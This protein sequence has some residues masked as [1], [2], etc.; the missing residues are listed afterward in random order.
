MSTPDRIERDITA[1]FGETAAPRPP[2]YTDDI[3][4]LTARSRQRPRWTFPERWFP[5]SV[6]TFGRVTLRPVPWRTV[7]LLVALALLLAVAAAVYVGSKP[8]SRSAAVRLGGQR[9]RRILE[10]RRHLHGRSDRP[11]RDK[12][13]SRAPPSTTAPAYLARRDPTRILPDD[14]GRLGDRPRRCRWTQSSRHPD[15]AA[16]RDVSGGLV[17]GWS[18]D[19]RRRRRRG[20]RRGALDRRYRRPHSPE[21]RRPR[22]R[23]RGAPLAPARW[24]PACRH[25]PG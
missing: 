9:P 14:G 6:I 17:A 3:L 2:D 18:M 1:W 23:R 12:R 16:G 20:R 24:T 25:R 22:P 15:D 10:G 11:A 5:M 19:R 8:A 21:D 4:Q 7:G 13:S